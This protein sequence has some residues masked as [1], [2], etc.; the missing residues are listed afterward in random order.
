MASLVGSLAGWSYL[1]DFATRLLLPYF[2]QG[3]QAVFKRP[4]PQQNTP[5]YKQH[6]RYV[7][8]AVVLS[9]LFYN[10]RDAALSMAPN[11]YEILGASPR[12][13][14]GTLKAAFRQFAKKNHPDR[15]GPQGEQLFMEV[16]DAF[17]ALKNPVT[18]FAYDR[19]G[20][21]AL[22]WKNCTTLR[23]YIRHGLMQSAGYHIVSICALLL[24]SAVGKQSPVSFWRYVLFASLFAYELVFL[25]SPSPTPP[26]TTTLSSFLFTDPASP[27]HN[28][29]LGLLWPNR[30]AYQHIR[31]LHSLFMLCSVAISRVSP[32]LFPSPPTLE[33]KQLANKLKEINILAQSADAETSAIVNI[34]LHSVHGAPTGVQP[35]NTTFPYVPP[36]EKPADEVMSLLTQEMENMVIEGKLLKEAE[37]GPLQTSVRMATERRR[38][39]LDGAGEMN[40]S[41]LR[42]PLTPSRKLAVS[43]PLGSPAPPAGSRP[44]Y[45]RARSQSC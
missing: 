29:I 13:D 24:Y 18:R 44:G 36:L 22:T 32:V 33:P 30:V 37:A 40:G 11:Y 9:Y 4:P 14:E 21:Q 45:V 3:Y 7:Y 43:R 23:E 5:L 10:F 35:T 31:F 38:R 1:P 34:D 20:P 17:E 15:V 12:S 16:R 39:Q 2:H 26:S 6:Y 19:F 42:I 8:A 25:L 41:P 28:S 27:S